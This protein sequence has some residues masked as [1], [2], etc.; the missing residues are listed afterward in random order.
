MKV[1]ILP[2]MDGTGKLLEPLGQCL[3]ELGLPNTILSYPAGQSQSYATIIKEIVEPALPEKEDFV[4]LAES[5]A[6]PMALTLAQ[7]QIPH[8]KGLVLV[9][10]FAAPP[11]SML[12]AL[13]GLLPMKSIMSI[14][15]PCWM[16][17]KIMLGGRM[18]RG[19]PD[20]FCQVIKEVQAE[21][22][23]YRAEQI[24]KLRLAS[25][26]ISLPCLYIRALDDNLLP[27][28]AV[29]GVKALVPNLEIHEI[30]GPHLVLDTNPER[31]AKIAAGFLRIFD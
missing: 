17:H 30:P 24:R 11:D 21:V 25:T 2:G 12:L 8:L 6:G 18:P 1:I 4:I 31:C 5:F 20:V 3:Q 29:D 19:D 15:V 23:A 28:N 9:V 7:R 26:P 14:P 10:T 27:A 13:S 16:A 22:M